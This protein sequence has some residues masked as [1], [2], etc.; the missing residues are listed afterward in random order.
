MTGT[1]LAVVGLVIAIGIAGSVLPVLPGLPVAW[2]AVLYWAVAE[3][4]GTGRW[5]VL[6]IA[7]VLMVVGV[8]AK[9]VLSTRRLRGQGAPRRTLAAAAVGG[10]LGFFLIPVVG[11]FVG[12]AAGA[13]L[14]EY[15]RHRRWEPAWSSAKTVLIALGIGTLVEVAAGVL[16]GLVWLVGVLTL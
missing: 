2:A 8:V 4:E 5:V 1:G 12:I 9:F 3:G 10:I 11:I 7:T 13:L 14:A 16:L 15:L 6:A